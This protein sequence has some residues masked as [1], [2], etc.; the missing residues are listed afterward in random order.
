MNKYIPAIVFFLNVLFG[1]HSISAFN[2]RSRS[3]E[4]D[5][6]R[7]QLQ[8]QLL[9][10]QTV[11]TRKDEELSACRAERNSQPEV[12]L[13]AEI[14]ILQIEKVR[15]GLDALRTSVMDDCGLCALAGSRPVL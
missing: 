2:S 3:Q 9:D 7:R 13:Q 5:S 1:H 14:S 8:Q 11:V 6:Q 4:S 15:E 12:K 10:L